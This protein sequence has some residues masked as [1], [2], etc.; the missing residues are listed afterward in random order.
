MAYVLTKLIASMLFGLGQ[1]SMVVAGAAVAWPAAC[2]RPGT[3]PARDAGRPADRSTVGVV[4]SLSQSWTADVRTQ[5]E[6]T[7]Y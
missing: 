1:G 4:V 5:P 6:N 2:W 3:S 7:L